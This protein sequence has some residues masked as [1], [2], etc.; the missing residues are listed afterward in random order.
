LADARDLQEIGYE[1]AFPHNTKALT[2][3]YVFATQR[4]QFVVRPRQI[5]PPLTPTVARPDRLNPSGAR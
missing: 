3:C 4:L 1:H 2:H 5:I